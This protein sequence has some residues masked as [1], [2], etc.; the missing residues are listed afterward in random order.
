MKLFVPIFR[1]LKYEEKVEVGHRWSKPYVATLSLHALF[2]F[3]QCIFDGP[4]LLDVNGTSLPQIL[5]MC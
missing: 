5:R 1:W 2:Q 3:R 4:V